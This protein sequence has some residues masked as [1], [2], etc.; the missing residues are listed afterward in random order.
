MVQ[1]SSQ[2]SE[3]D[4]QASFKALQGKFP[5]QLGSREAVIKRAELGEKGVYYRALVGPFASSDEAT[6]FCGN[7]K[8]AGGQCLVPRN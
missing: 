3:S 5:T 6:Q 7:L 8:T 1:L 2:R 4:A